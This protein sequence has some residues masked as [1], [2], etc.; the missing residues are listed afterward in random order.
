MTNLD[1]AYKAVWQS[2]KPLGSLNNL[3]E[4][5][6]YRPV[7]IEYRPYHKKLSVK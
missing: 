1:G 6:P 5:Y 3:L 7:W 2:Q 4:K